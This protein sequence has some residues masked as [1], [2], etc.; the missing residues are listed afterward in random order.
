MAEQ[1]QL[2]VRAAAIEDVDGLYALALTA[3]P[4]MTN[5]PPDRDELASRIAA[6]VAELDAADP[7]AAQ[8]MMLVLEAAGRVAGTGM[9]VSRV[10]AE[11]PFYSYKMSRVSQSSR[12][13]K[14]T[15]SFHVLS[16]VNDFEGHAEVGGLFLDSSLRGSGAGR[17]MSRGR[18]LFIAE[19]RYWFGEHIVAE[20]R[21]V[22]DEDGGSPFWDAVGRKFY[23]MDFG[24]ADR[25][26]A[27][28]GNQFIADLGPKF[29]IYV[30]LLPK[31]AQEALGQPHK[32]GR[33]AYDL[34]LAEGFRDEDY[35]D[36]FDGGP[37]IHTEVANLRCVREALV[38]TVARVGG[39]VAGGVDSLVCAGHSRE[40]RCAR[41]R[42]TRVGED[43][44]VSAALAEC[45]DVQP[46]ERIRHAP[47]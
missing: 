10:G 30:N 31:E 47:F 27:L 37:T 41:G 39:E 33:R 44:V 40:F 12:D 29:P 42:V 46:G 38:S 19:H 45:L 11:W 17:L 18:Y 21:G 7:G 3:G 8:P 4:G 20:L 14:R 34:L 24:E 35:V 22:Q 43:A 13:L 6:S 32:D 16:L 5:L 9:M 25:L 36:I 23:G 2:K 26:N 1:L 28:H 15:V